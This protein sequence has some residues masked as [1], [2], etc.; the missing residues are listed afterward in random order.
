MNVIS[1]RSSYWYT[2]KAINGMG[3]NWLR[4]SKV[5]SVALITDTS[6]GFKDSL[7]L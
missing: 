7:Y 5:S 1:L 4:I 6:D 3:D 2:A